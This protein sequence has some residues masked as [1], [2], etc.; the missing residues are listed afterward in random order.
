[1]FARINL[2]DAVKD[3]EF[4]RKVLFTGKNSQLVVMTLA[5]GEE[6][7]FE[8]HSVDQFI[9]VVKGEGCSVIG[10]D[11]AEFEEGDAI[12]IPAGELHNVVNTDDK[13]MRLFTILFATAAPCEPDSGIEA[14]RCH[15]HRIAPTSCSASSPA[16]LR[17]SQTSKPRNR[18]AA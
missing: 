1:M 15:R 18:L 7:G 3:N 9:Y 14:S 17:G 4:Y 5:P 16:V 10:K 12:C 6:I 11:A 13:P 8:T 2:K